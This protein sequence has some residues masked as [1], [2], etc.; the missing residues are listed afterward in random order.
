MHLNEDQ[1]AH[2][3]PEPMQHPSQKG[4]LII[5]SMDVVQSLKKTLAM[6]RVIHFQLAFISMI[7]KYIQHGN[8]TKARVLFDQYFQNVLKDKTRA[9]R[10]KRPNPAAEFEVHDK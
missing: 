8:Y 6:K 5:D 3:A 10:I 9:T 4:T 7:K 1:P 2:T